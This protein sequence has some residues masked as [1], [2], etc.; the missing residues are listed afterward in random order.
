MEELLVQLVVEF[1]KL[2]DL[3]LHRCLLPYEGKELGFKLWNKL[4]LNI[5]N[6]GVNFFATVVFGFL[7]FL[8]RALHIVYATCQLSQSFTQA[9][10]FSSN[11]F[12]MS[13][14][15]FFETFKLV[16]FVAV[17]EHGAIWAYR[18]FAGISIVLERCFVL[19]AYF[20]A[21]RWLSLSTIFL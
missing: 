17:A 3:C 19:L 5:F 8:D 1:F 14:V 9:N 18:L 11:G 16:P 6:K 2:L 20:S 21:P 4:C 7:D 10:S 12:D 13:F 15:Y